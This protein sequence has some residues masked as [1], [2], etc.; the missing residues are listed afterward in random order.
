M[1]QKIDESPDT[2]SAI[3]RRAGGF[4]VVYLWM[5]VP[6]I[7]LMAW[8]H[9]NAMLVLTVLA[10][11]LAGA[12]TFEWRRNPVGQGL[13]L[14]AAA[15]LAIL[16]MELVATLEGHAFQIDMHMYFFAGLALI[17]VF[18][19]WRAVLVYAGL[20]AVHHLVLNFIYPLAV[21]PD[22]ADFGRVLLHA[23]IVIVQT[24]A[25]LWL[26]R[27]LESGLS[28]S[29]EA[30]GIAR[31]LQAESERMS[32][33]RAALERQISEE[34]RT[35]MLN[36]A[37]RFE[38]DVQSSVEQLRGALVEVRSRVE[39]AI[40]M[41]GQASGKSV[42]VA[43]T[44]GEVAHSVQAIAVASEQLF[45]SSAQIGQKIGQTMSMA[46]EALQESHSASE[47]GRS[48]STNSARIG[49][50]VELIAD[51]AEQTNLLALNATIEAARAGE[52]G[53]GFAVVASEVKGLAQQTARATEEVR[54]EVAAIVAAI[55]AVA[56]GL[57]RVSQRNEAMTGVFSDVAAAVE[58]QQAST[59]EIARTI[60]V[61]ADSTSDVSNTVQEVSQDALASKDAMDRVADLTE[62]LRNVT[63]EVEGRAS[64]FLR[65]IRA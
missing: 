16:V 24:I 45:Q 35:G 52:A 34:R 53:K 9:G 2:L 38:S 21:F 57:E 55:N 11:I 44:T 18:C 42:G 23:G 40:A 58:E 19:N 54:K 33:E 14:T 29:D 47:A 31:R 48:L 39:L 17:G 20:V 51:I 15:A 60:R 49:E 6:V 32:Q 64:G 30:V 37:S 46:N 12:A 27:S 61:A 1:T 41:S 28:A 5:H 43:S 7:G 3:R 63:G 25:M 65:A 4:A 26:T 50:V 10:A 62:A 22:G 8:M 13:Q 36:L 59:R 56:H